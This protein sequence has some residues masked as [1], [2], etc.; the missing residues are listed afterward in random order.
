MTR[1]MQNSVVEFTQWFFH[2][3]S[4]EESSYPVIDFAM[5]MLAW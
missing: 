2:S 3:L 5:V 4:N 1:L